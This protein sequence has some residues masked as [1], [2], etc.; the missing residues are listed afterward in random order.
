MSSFPARI[1]IGQESKIIAAHQNTTRAALPAVII[2]RLARHKPTA[3]PPRNHTRPHH[4]RQALCRP[5]RHHFFTYADHL[6]YFGCVFSDRSPT[7]HAVSFLVPCS[8]HNYGL[9]GLK[10]ARCPD[11][12]SRRPTP[13]VR[14]GFPFN[15]ATAAAKNRSRRG[16]CPCEHGITAQD[17]ASMGPLRHAET[18]HGR[19]F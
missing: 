7:P 5:L 8:G 13:S 2:H 16:K 1:F 19:S 11:A 15:G 10:P 9:I 17:N 4:P 18:E 3:L 12:R 14:M 6:R